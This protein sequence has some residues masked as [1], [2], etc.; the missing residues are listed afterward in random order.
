MLFNSKNT[1]KHND[2]VI[3]IKALPKITMLLKIKTPLNIMML[4]KS[5][6]TTKHNDVVQKSKHH[7]T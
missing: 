4:F 1:T 6:N 3:K 7:R 2:V 5:Q